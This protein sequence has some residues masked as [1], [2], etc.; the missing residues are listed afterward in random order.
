M[1]T[2]TIRK[3]G[4]SRPFQKGFSRTLIVPK[5]ISGIFLL[6]DPKIRL[7]EKVENGEK[8]LL[9]TFTKTVFT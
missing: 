8:V 3:D 5:L 6:G 4:M 2:L 7:D 1:P 9:L